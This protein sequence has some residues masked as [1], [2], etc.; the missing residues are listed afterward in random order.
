M[1]S[2]Q[3]IMIQIQNILL[4]ITSGTDE[5]TM[6]EIGEITDFVQESAGQTADI[7]WGHGI[8]ETIGDKINVT[9]IATGFG[10]ESI[11]ELLAISKPEKR[12]VNLEEPSTKYSLNDDKKETATVTP[13][14]KHKLFDENEK[15]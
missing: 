9:I 13:T 4:N 3:T 6:D 12:I 15:K 14:E 10:N 7:I 5:I 11:P 8:D 2:L 1:L